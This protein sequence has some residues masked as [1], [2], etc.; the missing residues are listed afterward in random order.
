MP[1]KNPLKILLASNDRVDESAISASLTHSGLDS[2]V[3]RVEAEEEISRA[4]DSE[5]WNL[6]VIDNLV[7]V[8]AGKVVKLLED[9]QIETPYLIMYESLIEVSAAEILGASGADL[10]LTKTKMNA[11]GKT[12]LLEM[13]KA[14]ARMKK[15]IELEREVEGLLKAFGRALELRDHE[16]QG[17][18]ERVTSLSLKFAR[19][20]KVD[21][22]MLINIYQGSLAHDLGKLGIPDAI[23]LKDGKLTEEE[24]VAMRTHPTLALHLLEGIDTLKGAIAIPYCHHE[25]YDGTGYPR[26]LRDMDIPFEARIFSI[27]DV[28]D[29]VTSNRPYRL[30]WTKE[31]ALEYIMSERGKAFDPGIVLQFVNMM[32]EG[33]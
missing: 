1:A 23:L 16:T 10:Y 4:L 31:A 15:R 24:W 18:T 22:K 2:I 20:L 21:K 29:A 33:A 17:H 30:A 6:V 12:I 5:S 28:Y 25:K 11:V 8:T 13:G 19:V 14:G 26:G 3:R 32:K 27:V 9:R 7:A